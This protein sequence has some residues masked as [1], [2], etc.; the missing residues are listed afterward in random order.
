[1]VAT[2][3]GATA[4][5]L[6]K[7]AAALEKLARVSTLLIDK[8]GT[9]TEGRP[10]LETV[11]PVPGW[12]EQDLLRLGASLERA[13]EHPLARAIVEGAD[14]RGIE[15]L[16]VSNFGSV[17]GQ[18]VAGTVAGLEVL[19][20]NA[21]LLESRGVAVGA[22]EE[23]ARARRE[24]GETLVLVAVNGAP[25]GLLS[26]ADPIRAST[27]P[28]LAALV[29]D[30]VDVVMVTGDSRAT[31]V[32]VAGRLGLS[33]VE[34]EVTPDRKRAVVEEWQARGRPVAMAGDGVNDAP[35]L[36]KADVGIAMGTGTD[37]AIE[38]AGITLLHGDLGSLVRARRLSRATMTN[39]R[40]NLWFSFGYN[41]LGV[42]I[43][44]GLLYP[45]VGWLLSPM[46]AS[47]AMA[48]SSVSVIANALR[49]RKVP[50]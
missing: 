2:G 16:P 17:T 7:D 10:R 22:L 40:Q 47:A 23:R 15:L 26:V 34:A 38:S 4:G 28:A 37:V 50:L 8:T 48:L 11:E 44:A 49:L 42:P 35:A 36:A 6:F 18:G 3:R 21:R 32:A 20:G 39:I 24:R 5:V 46:V 1:M 30:G 45:L 31:A 41:A 33:R 12:T 9:L 19:L 13:S 27:P 25:A 29:A 43:A 14:G